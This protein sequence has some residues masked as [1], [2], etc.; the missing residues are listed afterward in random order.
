MPGYVYILASS[1]HGTLYV[2]VTNNLARRVYEHKIKQN[3]GFTTTYKVERLVWYE[4]YDR[5]YDAITRE[6]MIKKWR[7]DWKIRLIED[8]NPDWTDLYETLS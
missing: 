4:N 7:R 2:G 8:F 5:I 6:K 1:R 3:P